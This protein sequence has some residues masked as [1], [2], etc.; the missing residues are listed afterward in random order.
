MP[1]TYDQRRTLKKGADM[2]RTS[3]IYFRTAGITPAAPFVGEVTILPP[4]ALTSF[5]AIA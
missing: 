2:G 4:E 5:T 1:T 3:T